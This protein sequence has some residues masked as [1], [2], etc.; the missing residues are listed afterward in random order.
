M[1][2]TNFKY[3]DKNVAISGMH[4]LSKKYDKSVIISGMH[5]L[6]TAPTT[7]LTLKKKIVIH[8]KLQHPVTTPSHDAT[9]YMDHPPTQNRI[10]RIRCSSMCTAAMIN[11]QPRLVLGY[12]WPHANP[13]SR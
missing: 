6:Q 5:K 2:C 13:R 7:G 8:S 10:R 3:D 4:K 9:T 11:Q 12:A 1:A